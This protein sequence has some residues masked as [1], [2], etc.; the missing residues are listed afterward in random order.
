MYRA[1]DLGSV[2]RAACSRAGISTPDAV[3]SWAMPTRQLWPVSLT[4]MPAATPAAVIRP[5]T[6]Q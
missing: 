6:A 5:P 1:A 3:K 2:Q 4:S